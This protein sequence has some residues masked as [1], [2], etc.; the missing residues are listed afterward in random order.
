[1]KRLVS[2]FV[3]VVLLGLLFYKVDRSELWGHVRQTH[4]GWF[5][6]ALFMFIP[7]IWLIALRWRKLVSV[8]VHVPWGEA[9]A[10]ILASNTMNL[11]L[12]S[13]LGDLAKGVFLERTGRLDLGRA[14]NVVIFEKM[15]DVGMLAAFMLVGVGLMFLGGE[16][17]AEERHAVAV[18]AALGTAAVV[19][20]AV[21]YFV[22]IEKFHFLERVLVWASA[23]PRCERLV[24]W[25]RAG[26]QTISLLQSR[27]ARRGVIVA[28]SAAIWM[29]HLGQIYFFFRA[30]GAA[31]LAV[32][33]FVSKVPL[34]IF[35]GLVPL[36]VA[37]FGTRDGALVAL[38]R[39][40]PPS[41]MLGVA[42]YVNLRY[43][44][45]ALAGIP[46]LGRYL[47]D[48][49]SLVGE[50]GRASRAGAGTQ[51]IA[52]ASET[53][54][55]SV[56]RGAALVGEP[57][58]GRALRWMSLVLGLALWLTF[59]YVRH[60]ELGWN[61]RSRLCLTFAIVERGTVCIDDYWTRPDLATRDVATI[62][63]HYY[64][65]KIIGTSVL[66]VP[67]FAAV[68][69]FEHV[70]G[71]PLPT[72]WRH[73]IV[74]ALSTALLGAGAAVLFFR[75]AI[76]YLCDLGASVGRA[77]GLAAVATVLTF[78]G[79]MLLLY[80]NL[81]MPY[82]PAIFFLLL[83]LTLIE[84]RAEGE[85]EVR[86]AP[87]GSSA[88]RGQVR[89]AGLGRVRGGSAVAIGRWRSVAIGACLGS[90]ILC[91]YLAAW[92]ALLFWGLLLWRS[93]SISRGALS[94]A[95]MIVTLVPF[96]AYSWVIFGRV[97]IPYTY[98]LDPLFQRSMARGLM[99]ATVPNP[100]VAYL[101]SIHPYRGLFF[102]SPQLLVGVVGLVAGWRR[103]GE[104]RLRSLMFAAIF[105]G[106]FLY[107]SAYYMWW[108]GWGFAPRFLAYGVPVLGL[109]MLAAWE[110]G[111][112]REGD[113]WARPGL[114][115]CVAS[116]V[117]GLWG[118]CVHVIVHFTTADFPDRPQG[119][120]LEALLWP[121]LSRYDYPAIFARYF[122]RRFWLGDLAWNAGRIG[123][124][125][126]P[127]ST[128]PIVVVWG[129]AAV[130]MLWLVCR[131]NRRAVSAAR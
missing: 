106:L 41:R 58:A 26:Q 36:T 15:L 121:D 84:E 1:M 101:L 12:P 108:G 131:L 2:V 80:S 86:P 59:I 20:V 48:V 123:G 22:P 77:I 25:V 42:L 7:Q 107:N 13:K 79:T 83:A 50:G 54:S 124:L 34:A 32:S 31:P 75:L 11:V 115:W 104:W 6:A 93:G 55:A 57:S 70:R 97:S 35:I 81:L 129:L 69:V 19:A 105:L 76:R 52:D 125:A 43:I 66:A 40:F 63:G 64:S 130:M 114:W 4:W 44:V 28:L 98:E 94:A 103:G 49:R 126:G 96:V 18:A 51:K 14:M 45:P 111:A 60:D 16:V 39:E 29:A 122:W 9:V 65:D 113:G 117:A 72:P 67:A 119:A 30:L 90:A 91:D 17:R 68:R 61:V 5:A 23:V 38:F 88:P 21:V 127:A 85:G 99:G 109:A 73:W 24:R 89:L 118:I 128:W 37:G 116:V 46:F 27:G 3:S 62:G 71:E 110:S 53:S 10:Q 74:A 56:V 102:Y 92:P 112:K 33:E 95:A 8:F 82:L 47:A 78:T 120:P 87:L 100:V